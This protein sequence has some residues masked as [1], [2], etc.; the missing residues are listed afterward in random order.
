MKRPRVE[1]YR[2]LSIHTFR[3]KGQW[4]G[5]SGNITWSRGNVQY[6]RAFFTVQNNVIILSWNGRQGTVTQTIPITAVRVSYGNRYFFQCPHCNR[7]AVILYLEQEF[8]CRKCCG[9]T[10]ESCQESHGRFHKLLGLTDS[11][12]R[13]FMKVTEYARELGTKKRTGS[14]MLDRLQRY[15]DKS[16]VIFTCYRT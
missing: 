3:N 9:L 4:K 5:T 11:Q 12:F 7:R 10:Y 2:N 13:N 6:A 16:G 8:V 15:I 14:R 1:N